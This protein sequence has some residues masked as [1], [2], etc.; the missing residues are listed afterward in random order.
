M[1]PAF[2]ALKGSKIATGPVIG[3]I[4]IVLHGKT[5]TAMQAFG[6]QLTD[7]QIAAIIT[8]ERNSWGNDD[9]SKYGKA[10]GG[11]VQPA[12]VAKSRTKLRIAVHEVDGNVHC[13][14]ADL[15]PSEHVHMTE[16]TR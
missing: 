1:P 6:N 4:N 5:G 3:H 9:Q 7:E 2:P 16:I 10:A 11:I 14:Y 8:Y 13:R 15:A 12:E